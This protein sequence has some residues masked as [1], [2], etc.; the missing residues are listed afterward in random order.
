M[1]ISLT[2]ENFDEAIQNA[3]KPVV[4]DFWAEWCL[5]PKS[6]L[7]FNPEVREIKSVKEGSKILSFDKNFQEINS[8]AEKV[9]QV[10][11]NQK[12][13]I[14]TERGREISCDPDHLILT[15]NGFKKAKDLK[16]G[17]SLSTY[18]FS[19]FYYTPAKDKRVFLNETN[20]KEVAEKL[21]LNQE[22]YINQLR[23]KDLLNI[24]Y[25]QE[26]AY[27]LASLVGFL[28]TDGS[29]SLQKNNERLIE[30]S[31]GRKEDLKE[32]IKD[33]EF[34]GFHSSIRRKKARKGEIAGRE[35]TQNCF[36][37]RVAK[38]NLF[39]LLYALGGII[40]EKFFKGLRI[41][42]WILNGP[43]EIQ[44]AFLQGFLGGDGP[45]VTI[46]T[47]KRK[48]RGFY[49][50]AFI[51]PI[52]FH[53]CSRPENSI[54][55]FVKDFSILLN[56]FNIKT[57]KV[58]F[59]KENKYKRKDDR[60][61]KLLKIWLK[62]NLKNIHAYSS[63]G[64]KYSYTKKLTSALAKTYLTERLAKISEREKKRVQVL[65]MINKYSVE[66]I[67]KKLNL[68][69]S[70]IYN[71]LRGCKAFPP[72]DIIPY[73]KWLKSY[74]EPTKKI[75]FD[76]IKTIKNYNGKNYKFISLKLDNDTKTFV[77][78]GIIHHNCAPCS[79]LTPILEKL[80]SEFEGKF[81]LAKVNLNEARRT[82]Q[83]YGIERIP[84]VI[85]FQEGK[86]VSGFIGARPESIVRE[87]LNKMLEDTADSKNTENIEKIIK[88]YQEYAE[89]NGFKL[90]PSREVVERLIKG[91]LENEKKYGQRYCP[92][93]RVTGN[94]EKDKGKICPCQ[95][96]REE[97]ERD[98]HCFCGLFVK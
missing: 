40:G 97:I 33:L 46:R 75:I 9:Y 91:M 63:I 45:K 53:F 27:I 62:T 37:V 90:N 67:S 26:K 51:N 38:T 70:V 31:L 71:W 73:K 34:L 61:S 50:K 83:K 25:S 17:D 32:L 58:E 59:T 12:I 11:L 7:I 16:I 93:R 2:D 21:N 30:F 24:N 72:Q 54:K 56:N 79:I 82:S 98:G 29:L 68:N 47:V 14:K 35:F 8:E 65:Q 6:K 80:V 64:F 36:K 49:N 19:D 69:F 85:L 20:V 77:A 89:K 95:W 74:T 1:K 94:K 76:K 18:L 81:I 86:P 43:K 84:M 39:I 22:L 5:T 42:K 92:C 28:L 66:D 15:K 78:N 60:E 88:G 44:R 57:R 10:V 55:N 48:N 87:L 3:N 4:V 52:E 23:E 96:H 41:P 13:Q